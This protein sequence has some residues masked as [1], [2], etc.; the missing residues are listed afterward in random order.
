MIANTTVQS[1]EKAGASLFLSIT[2][3]GVFYIP[4]LLTLNHLFEFK[5]LIYAQPVSD[6]MTLASSYCFSFN[7][8][9]SITQS[10]RDTV[11]KFGKINLLYFK[12]RHNLKYE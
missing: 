3:Q 9:N 10:N 5:G 7:I 1:M 12:Y 4:L 8:K 2:R 11:P 6:I